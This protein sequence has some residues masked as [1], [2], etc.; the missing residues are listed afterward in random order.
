MREMH[1]QLQVAVVDTE[2]RPSVHRSK[3]VIPKVLSEDKP[4]VGEYKG[5][6]QKVQWKAVCYTDF[7][8]GGEVQRS[9]RKPSTTVGRGGDDHHHMIYL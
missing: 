2:S 7:D 9:T 6:F 1:L 3:G 5:A 4:S 8:I